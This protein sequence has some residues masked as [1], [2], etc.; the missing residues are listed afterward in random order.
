LGRCKTPVCS[1]L[2]VVLS[3]GHSVAV[4]PLSPCHTTTLSPHL[5]TVTPVT[6]SP[7]K[8]LR[9]LHAPSGLMNTSNQVCIQATT[10]TCVFPMRP[11]PDSMKW[12]V[13]ISQRGH[14]WLRTEF[15]CVTYMDA[16]F[17]T[18]NQYGGRDFTKTAFDKWPMVI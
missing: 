18:A 10:C 5:V 9:L 11:S 4:S 2:P 15:L 6:L 8:S 16:G 12:P 7:F 14:C 3:P 13:V 1:R 17:Q